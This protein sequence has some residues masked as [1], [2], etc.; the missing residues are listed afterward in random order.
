VNKLPAQDE[1]SEI[2]ALLGLDKPRVSRALDRKHLVWAG[3]AAF[4][5]LLVISV[6]FR[7]GP[8]AEQ[9]FVVE[10]ASGPI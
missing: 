10:P 1:H 4:V 9:T 7:G 3:L 5:L 8:S 2:R 6:M